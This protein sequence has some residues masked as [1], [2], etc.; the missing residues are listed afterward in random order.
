[1]LKKS[2]VMILGFINLTANTKFLAIM[3]CG[4]IVA[5]LLMFAYYPGNT[6]KL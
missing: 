4:G 3:F 6:W 1:M 5:M 2:I